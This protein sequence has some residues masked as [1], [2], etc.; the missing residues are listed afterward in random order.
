LG[1]IAVGST[2]LVGRAILVAAGGTSVET[3]VTGGGFVPTR[4]S[5]ALQATRMTAKRN[6]VFGRFQMTVFILCKVIQRCIYVPG[7]DRPG[8]F[9]HDNI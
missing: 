3:S 1:G 4:G 8:V 5:S 6:S 2:R 7:K 9:A